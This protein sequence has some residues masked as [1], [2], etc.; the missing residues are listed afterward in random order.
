MITPQMQT[1]IRMLNRP[2]LKSKPRMVETSDPDQAPVPGIG[3][4]VNMVR[5]KKPYFSSSA[6]LFWSFC[7]YLRKKGPNILVVFSHWTIFIP[8][9]SRNGTGS[10]LA[11]THI[12]K[13]FC[14]G[15]P[16]AAPKIM[17]PLSSMRGI[18]EIMN[19]AASLPS[20]PNNSNIFC[21]I[22]SSPRSLT[23]TI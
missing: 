10:M 15:I 3:K 13:T 2:F 6:D 17:A 20:Q 14:H 7:S 5:A 19:S 18:I 21:A 4:A 22:C 11:R 12:G 16:L 8:K 9:I 23:I 1:P